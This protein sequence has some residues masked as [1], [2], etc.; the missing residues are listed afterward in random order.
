MTVNA[1]T[2]DDKERTPTI[3][4]VPKDVVDI[5]L[6][7]YV[8]DRICPECDTRMWVV[9]TERVDSTFPCRECGVGLE[10]PLD[11]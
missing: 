2:P 6:H 8:K 3:A 5:A 7:D 1:Q 10:V 9:E 4:A 11:E